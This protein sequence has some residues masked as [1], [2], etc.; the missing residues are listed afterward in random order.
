MESMAFAEKIGFAQIHV[1]PYSRRKGTVADKM[2]G[3]LTEAV[4]HERE[5]RFLE[6][7]RKLRTAYYKGLLGKEASVMVE[8]MTEEDGVMYANG[9]CPRYGTYRFPAEHSLSGQIVTVI[10]EDIITTDGII[11]AKMVAISHKIG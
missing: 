1:F 11:Q 3:Q 2:D 4:K 9:H 8:D 5:V 10:G 7:E 6:M